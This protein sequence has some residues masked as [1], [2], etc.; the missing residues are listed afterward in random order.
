MKFARFILGVLF[1]TSCFAFCESKLYWQA[2]KGESYRIAV[3][4]S[5]EGAAEIYIKSPQTAG[6]EL[7]DIKEGSMIGWR[8]E[9]LTLQELN[10]QSQGV[11]LVKATFLD[12][13]ANV[14]SFEIS[15]GVYASEFPPVPS[16][17]YPADDDNAVI[18]ENCVFTWD[19]NGA[20][21][22][23]HILTVSCEGEDYIYA[24]NSGNGAIPIT[25]T[26][27]N[28]GWLG[29]GPAFMKVGYGVW[30]MSKRT[31]FSHVSGSV[32]NWDSI[33]PYAVWLTGDRV[34]FNVTK[35]A[36][37]NNDGVIDFSDFVIIA[38]LWLQS[39]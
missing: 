34:E 1:L 30:M 35:S 32:M 28:P 22:C 38:K 3:W 18:A 15:G 6:Y 16:I 24:D 8:M 9:N 39:R 31:V 27:W 20:D 33:S 14:S 37:L 5:C 29:Q 17:T 21:T 23:S 12:K 11:W 36:D 10:A 19:S 4:A 7:L 2:V 26:Q 25:L 13:P